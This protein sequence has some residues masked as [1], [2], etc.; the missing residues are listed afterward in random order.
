LREWERKI[1]GMLMKCV[2]EYLLDQW[3]CYTIYL[4]TDLS[5]LK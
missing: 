1:G 5:P 2:C 3:N 4:K